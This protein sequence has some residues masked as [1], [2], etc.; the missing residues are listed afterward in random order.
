MKSIA[1]LYDRLVGEKTGC[2][3]GEDV[4]VLGRSYG[5][6][7]TVGLVNSYNSIKC[8][9]VINPISQWNTLGKKVIAGSNDGETRVG[10][11][12]PGDLVGF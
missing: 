12:D 7:L 5:A 4:C 6:W 3:S 9:V 8:A 11:P 1:C 2:V 10:D